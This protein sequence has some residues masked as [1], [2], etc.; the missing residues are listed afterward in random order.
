MT[1]AIFLAAPQA[2]LPVTKQNCVIYLKLHVLLE[3]YD[4]FFHHGLSHRLDACCFQEMI[5]CWSNVGQRRR[6]WTNIK[7]ALGQCVAFG[8]ALIL[9]S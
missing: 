5:Q 1:G 4:V 8:T 7:P 9:I 6:W 3:S 2:I